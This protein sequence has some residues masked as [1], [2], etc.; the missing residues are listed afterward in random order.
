MPYH[1]NLRSNTGHT[2]EVIM[3]NDPHGNR[4]IADFIPQFNTNLPKVVY[5]FQT[6]QLCFELADYIR[7]IG[8]PEIWAEHQRL[9]RLQ[10][11]P[12]PQPLTRWARI[13]AWV[14][15]LF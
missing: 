9:L 6:G 10:N 13:K 3:G 12:P 2:Y 14:R 1:F 4:N 5:I 7:G 11:Q 8:A 15:R